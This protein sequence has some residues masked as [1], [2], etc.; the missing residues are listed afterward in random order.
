MRNSDDLDYYL[1]PKLMG[2]AE[3]AW[4]AEP[5]WTKGAGLGARR[6]GLRYDWGRFRN[7]VGQVELPLL[8]Y[9]ESPVEY[10]IPLPAARVRNGILEVNTLYPGLTMRYSVDGTDPSIDGNEVGTRVRLDT[11][12]EIRVR[13]FDRTGRGGRVFTLEPTSPSYQK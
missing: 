9:L 2:L 3:R 5:A 10:R 1:F 4:A 11:T 6:V 12:S 8:S 13:A 7:T